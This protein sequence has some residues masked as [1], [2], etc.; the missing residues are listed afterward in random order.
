MN[1]RQIW[2][3]IQAK[4]GNAY[5][6]AAL[7]GNLMAESSLNPACATGKNK[8]ANYTKDVDNGEVDFVNDG[9]AFGLVQWC[10]HARKDGLLSYARSKGK[11]VSDLKTQLEYM[12]MEL[13]DYYKTAYNAVMDATNIRTASDV[14]ML[15]YEK[16]A[17]T[18]ESAREKRASYGQ[19]FFEQFA[20]TQQKPEN[21]AKTQQ[22]SEK[23]TVRA[24]E[25]VNIRSG[26]GK[27]N[28]KVGV[29]KKGQSLEWIAS[30]NGWYKVAVWVSDEF[31]EVI[32]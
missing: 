19:K 6:T 9:V 4:T 3:F 32:S 1:E 8:T 14:V 5:G 26:P 16:P 10:Y 24:T 23:K 25:A 21:A 22:G 20:G 29:L 31:S 17:N 11:S 18:G 30:E 28:V 12:W 13:R 27:S 2:D 15:R 7:M